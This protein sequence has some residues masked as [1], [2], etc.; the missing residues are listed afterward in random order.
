MKTT[1]LKIILLITLAAFLISFEMPAGWFKAGSKSDS[2]DMG[3]DKGAGMDGKNAASIKSVDKVIEGYGTLMQSA[4]ADKFIGKRIRLSGYIK[5]QNVSEKAGFWLRIGQANSQSFLAF[6]N[7]MDRAVTGTTDWKKH[8]IVL[9]VP[10]GASQISYG[11]LLRGTGQ[12]WFDKLNF[13][14]VDTNVPTTGKK[15]DRVKV[16]DE[17]MNLDF[18]D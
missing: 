10:E 5:S 3:I 8:E 15:A 14:I 13:E 4:N 2:Y 16:K 12:I 18:E 9:D 11:A 7:M 1:T 17:P 6:D